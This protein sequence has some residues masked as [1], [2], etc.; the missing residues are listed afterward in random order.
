MR[1]TKSRSPEVSRAWR[2]A[3]IYSVI[4]VLI[5]MEVPKPARAQEFRLPPAPRNLAGERISS[6]ITPPFA[7]G[8]AVHKSHGI[9]PLGSTFPANKGVG[10][11]RP[12]NSTKQ[13]RESYGIFA[14]PFTAAKSQSAKFSPAL[15]STIKALRNPLVH[16]LPGFPAQLGGSDKRVALRLFSSTVGVLGHEQSSTTQSPS[17]SGKKNRTQGLI[18]GLVGLAISGTGVYLV[19]TPKIDT[20]PGKPICVPMPC[21]PN[22]PVCRG[23]GPICTPGWPEMKTH[24][25]KAYGGLALAIGGGG[26]A[27]MGFRQMRR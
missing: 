5:H 15:L 24:W 14:T 7:V 17:M 19:A 20:M 3:L 1:K 26:M 22:D 8:A 10:S 9:T 27:Y 11:M 16:E 25:G 12:G 23:L 13:R 6:N 18:L 21:I 4:A 2:S